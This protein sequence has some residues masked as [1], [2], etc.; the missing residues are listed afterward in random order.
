MDSERNLLHRAN[1][2]GGRRVAGGH[3]VSLADPVLGGHDLLLSL[4]GSSA[5][6]RHSA[7]ADFGKRARHWHTGSI[8]GDPACVRGIHRRGLA[9]VG[10]VRASVAAYRAPLDIC[11]GIVSWPL[12]AAKLVRAGPGWR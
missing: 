5:D 1:P 12:D 8:G 9:V 11:E 3:T 6:R 7:W 4:S 2:D 10:L